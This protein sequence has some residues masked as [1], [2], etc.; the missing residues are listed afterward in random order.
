MP[1]PQPNFVEQVY[2]HA[3]LPDSSGQFA[4][5]VI[6]D[7]LELGILLKWSSKEFPCFFEWLHLREGAYA[8]GLEP[9]THHVGGEPA[10]RKDGT[11]IWLEHA[12]SRSYRMRMRALDGKK[13]IEEAVGRIRAV[14]SQPESDVP[15]VA[16]KD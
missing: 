5:A 14:G 10:A 3:V 16:R 15:F 1:A 11:M 4:V 2:E 8:I 13:S 6:N 7:R 9:S 12:E